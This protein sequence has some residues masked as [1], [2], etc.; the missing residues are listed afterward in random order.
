MDHR[1]PTDVM[2]AKLRES[3]VDHLDQASIVDLWFRLDAISRTGEEVAREW[4]YSPTWG[5]FRP[6]PQAGSI[7]TGAPFRL[8]SGNKS[9]AEITRASVWPA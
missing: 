8:S 6:I 7:R 5:T 2:S 9:C 4:D 1:V 3:R